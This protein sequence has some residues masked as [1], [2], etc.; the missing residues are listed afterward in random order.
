MHPMLETGH[1]T[2]EV[3]FSTKVG[4]IHQLVIL[5]EFRRE[6]SL[7]AAK[8]VSTAGEGG[9]KWAAIASEF[10]RLVLGDRSGQP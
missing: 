6:L 4:R 10:S 7:V 5:N 3:G 9:Q 2:S 1:K 8:A